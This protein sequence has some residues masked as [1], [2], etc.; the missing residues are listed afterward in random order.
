MGRLPVRYDPDRDAA[1][2][3]AHEQSFISCAEESLLSA[4]REL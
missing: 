3:R 1:V 2:A 4:P